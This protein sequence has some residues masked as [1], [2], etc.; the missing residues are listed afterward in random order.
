MT[1]QHKSGAKKSSLAKNLMKKFSATQ[2]CLMK[3]F[4][5]LIEEKNNLLQRRI[6]TCCKEES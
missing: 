3:K 2:N 4:S 6:I 5:S 1:C